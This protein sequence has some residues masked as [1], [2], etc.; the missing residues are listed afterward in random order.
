MR[1]DRS[2]NIITKLILVTRTSSTTTAKIELRVS[3]S[4]LPMR[5]VH[6]GLD[7]GGSKERED[8]GQGDNKQHG[9][10]QVVQCKHELG[11]G[12]D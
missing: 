2:D 1:N 12:C 9:Q 6:L 4:T 8:E 11:Q 10:D 5:T 7:A 3:S